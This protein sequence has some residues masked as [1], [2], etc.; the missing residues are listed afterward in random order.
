MEGRGSTFVNRQR[1][2]STTT[3]QVCFRPGGR[4][5]SE[6]FQTTVHSRQPEV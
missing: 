3:E 4:S 1:P 2:N 5:N 6:D